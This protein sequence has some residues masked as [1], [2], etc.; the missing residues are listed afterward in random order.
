MLVSHG[1]NIQF[2]KVSISI[3]VL[4]IASLQTF[5]KSTLRET[6]RLLVGFSLS[7]LAYFYPIR[8]GGRGSQARI[9]SLTASI[10]KPLG[11]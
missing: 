1:V 8:P 6:H 3:S 2:I 9:T 4:S 10:L 5:L 7:L 11:V